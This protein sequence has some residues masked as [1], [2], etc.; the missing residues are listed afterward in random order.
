MLSNIGNNIIS[1]RGEKSRTFKLGSDKDDLYYKTKAVMT[2]STLL[3]SEDHSTAMSPSGDFSR[4]RSKVD[5]YNEIG[6]KSFSTVTP[7]INKG[8]QLILRSQII[9]VWI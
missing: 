8:I 6:A 1:P 4:N 2:P 9:T 7:R 5:L 3:S